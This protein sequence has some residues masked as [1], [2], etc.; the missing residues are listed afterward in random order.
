[1][2]TTVQISLPGTQAS[3]LQLCQ[4]PD[5]GAGTT[6]QKR[7]RKQGR[8]A[9]LSFH[10]RTAVDRPLVRTADVIT[11]APREA[12]RNMGKLEKKYEACKT[13]DMRV[14]RQKLK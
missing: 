10:Y 14:A 4:K 1:M 8:S 2:R 3:R 9:P 12:K 13:R 5:D 11:L 6:M 7:A